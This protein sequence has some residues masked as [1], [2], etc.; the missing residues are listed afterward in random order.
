MSGRI[1]VGAVVLAVGVLWLLSVTGVVDLGYE[2]WI[3]LLLIVIGL[4]IVL[5]PGRH[6][7][8]VVAGIV[9]IL[10]GLPTLVVDSSVFSGGA[11][12][13]VETPLTPTDLS[14]YHHGVGKLTVDLTS[15]GLRKANLAVEARN[16]IGE[17]LV[18]VPAVADVKVDAHVGIGNIDALG[19]ME[20]GLGVDLEDSF[21][22]PG[23]Q[24]L[25]LDLKAGIGDIRVER[26]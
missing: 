5:T 12:D 4:A 17:L 25:S 10:A 3:G 1:A 15:P 11:G 6:G 13:A 24:Q 26:G 19:R 23:S 9:V 7:W 8:L 20:N 18:I 2:A 16:G 21:P 22:G 14:H